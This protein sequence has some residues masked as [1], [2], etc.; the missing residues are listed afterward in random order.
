MA[1]GKLIYEDLRYHRDALESDRELQTLVKWIPESSNSILEI[2][3]HTG[4]LGSILKG[5][6]LTGIDVNANAIAHAKPF[7]K[8][9]VVGSIE[10]LEIINILAVEK[11]SVV[12]MMHVLE[13]LV[14]PWGTLKI[15]GGMLEK[16]G[17]VIIALPNISNM[18]DRV[19]MFSGEFRYEETGV[20]DKTHL[21]FFNYPTACQLISDAG[22]EVIEYFAP[23]KVDAPFYLAQL[24][25]PRTKTLARKFISQFFSFSINSTDQVMMFLCKLRHD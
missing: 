12:T 14:D 8:N 20:M 16:D 25:P 18:Q 17:R 1:Q 10:D 9:L 15:L 19:K 11:Y 24:F 5:K 2:G 22:L 4:F 13:H 23:H 7:Y 6:Q 3:C 21:R